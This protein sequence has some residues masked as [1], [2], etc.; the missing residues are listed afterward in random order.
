MD[1]IERKET[2]LRNSLAGGDNKIFSLIGCG[3]GC[4][5]TRRDLVRS[6]IWCPAHCST[7]YATWPLGTLS[8]FPS[9]SCSL[10]LTMRWSEKPLRGLYHFRQL[11]RVSSYAW[12]CPAVG[13]KRWYIRKKLSCQHHLRSAFW[14][15]V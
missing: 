2:H 14:A 12:I 11:L 10:L 9:K 13:V 15:E 1:G 6:P 5:R 4:S 3:V 8:F 7:S